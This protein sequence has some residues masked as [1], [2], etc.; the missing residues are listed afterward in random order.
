MLSVFLRL[1]GLARQLDVNDGQRVANDELVIEIDLDVVGAERFELDVRKEVHVGRHCVH[2]LQAEIHG[3]FAEDFFIRSE[4]LRGLLEF[5]DA[6]A[7]AGPEAQLQ[8]TDGNLWRGHGIDDPDEGL[9]AGDFTTDVFAQ[10]GRLAVWEHVF[11][12]HAACLR[13]SGR[14]VNGSFRVRPRNPGKRAHFAYGMIPVQ[15]ASRSRRVPANESLSMSRATELF[16]IQTRLAVGDAALVYRAVDPS[17]RRVALKLLLPEHLIAHP[18]DVESLLRDAPQLQTIAGVNIVQL[19]D[20]FPDDDGTVLVYEYAEGHRGLDVPNNRPIAAEHAVD[21]AAQL[22]SALRSGERQR[23]PHGDLKPSDTVIVD[24]PDGRPLVMVLDWGL[25]NYRS[26]LTP[27]SYA[28]TAPERLAGCPPSHVADLFS[29]GAVLHYLFTGKRLLPCETK[30]EFM[31]AWPGLDVNALAVMRPDLPKALVDWIALLIAPDPAARPE[32]AVKA[33]EALAA[34]NPPLPPAVPEHIRPRIVRAPQPVVQPVSKIQPRPAPPPVAAPAQAAPANPAAAAAA[35]NRAKQELDRLARKRQSLALM[36]TYLVVIAGLAF[37]GWF[38]YKRG[39]N[40]SAKPEE[41]TLASAA[42]RTP[43]RGAAEPAASTPEPPA[44]EP[45]RVPQPAPSVAAATPA[46]KAPAPQPQ[47]APPPPKPPEPAPAANPGS[48]AVESFQYAGGAPIVGSSGGVGWEGPWTGGNAE[49]EDGAF[50]NVTPVSPGGKLLFKPAPN[51]TWVSRIVDPAVGLVDQKSGGVYYFTLT[52]SHTDSVF[53]PESEFQYNPIDPAHQN[54]PLRVIIGNEGKGF[55]V[56]INDRKKVIKLPNTPGPI[57]LVQ[58]FTF[59]P[60]ANNR[61][62]VECRLFVN[63]PAGTKE[64]GQPNMI[65]TGTGFPMP[66]K[67]GIALRKK[68]TPTTRV[69]EVRFAKEWKDL[70]N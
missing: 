8:E 14:C 30:D 44:P 46:P 24:L 20:A 64:P 54:K 40:P 53:T 21:I 45:A 26:E 57:R 39:L 51:D 41:S 4:Q 33:L 47:P 67:I 68:P 27:G 22:L 61:W 12:K 29:A 66:A 58:K 10:D 19:L 32:S 7:P 60:D 70:F 59:T 37:G 34:L 17:G 9:H 69:D 31:A 56:A 35:L 65:V 49:I 52:F 62:K 55:E 18:L 15:S 11:I 42:G 13:Q 23:Y 5:T 1:R 43:S 6:V 63:P 50:P 2:F 36:T 28:Y 16:E 38:L 3:A 25:A 48:R